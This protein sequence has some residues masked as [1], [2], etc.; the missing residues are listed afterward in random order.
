MKIENRLKLRVLPVLCLLL[1]VLTGCPTPV[2]D[3][4]NQPNTVT[5]PDGNAYET[6]TIG[7]QVWMAENL[8]TTKF[9][10]GSPIP[11]VVIASSWGALTTPGYCWYNNETINQEIYGALYN[12]YT[13]A[14]TK[15]CPTGWHVPSDSEWGTMTTYLGGEL[16]ANLKIRESGTLHWPSP[17]TAT[18]STGFSAVPGGC[19]DANG[20]FADA[21]YYN[22]FWANTEFLNIPGFAMNRQIPCE[23]NCAQRATAYSQKSGFSVRCIKD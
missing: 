4:T 9:N 6:V 2:E 18:N 22:Y 23:N 14:T 1:I 15:L 16:A 17:N 10:D 5:D 21:K 11:H 13:I 20:V 3:N 19:R 12:W 7:T 8:K